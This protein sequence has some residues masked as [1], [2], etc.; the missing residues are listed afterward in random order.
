MRDL[1]HGRSLV[2]LFSVEQGVVH[3]LLLFIELRYLL[4]M[5]IMVVV[6]WY[7]LLSRTCAPVQVA[8]IGGSRLVVAS[9]V[10]FGEGAGVLGDDVVLEGGEPIVDGQVH[11]LLQGRV[12]HGLLDYGFNRPAFLHLGRAVWVVRELPRESSRLPHGGD[13]AN[14]TLGVEA[15]RD[16]RGVEGVGSRIVLIESSPRLPHPRGVV[17]GV[18]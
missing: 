1:R 10:E 16:L 12:Q 2:H 3:H 11:W 5:V 14:P 6:L 18:S 7:G 9:I 8:P 4:P 17:V 13:C 15:F